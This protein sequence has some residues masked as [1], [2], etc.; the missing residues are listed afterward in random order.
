MEQVAFVE[1][2]GRE[3][4]EWADAR[5]LPCPDSSVEVLYSSH[6]LEHLDQA[7]AALFLREAFRVL[8]PGGVIRIA[9]PDLRRLVR[10]YLVAGDANEFIAGTNL[11]APKARSFAQRLRL[12]LVGPRH[13][14]WFY[15]GQ[16]LCQLLEGSGFTNAIDLPAGKTGIPDPAGLD[17]RERESESLYVEA[18]KPMRT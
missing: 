2:A 6:M 13:H 5:R 12:A 18:T 7:E 14:H 3:R 16:S 17:L 8:R 4:L 15:D 1:C 11:T 10:N 9:V